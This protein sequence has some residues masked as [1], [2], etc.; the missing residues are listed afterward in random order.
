[1][2]KFALI[3]GIAAEWLTGPAAASM[4]DFGRASL[5]ATMAM[6][7]AWIV[8]EALRALVSAVQSLDG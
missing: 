1:M 8:L 5:R 6:L 3:F 4:A 2:L 7:L